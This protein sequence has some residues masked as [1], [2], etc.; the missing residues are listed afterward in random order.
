MSKKYKTCMRTGHTNFWTGVTFG[1]EHRGESKMEWVER[2]G[3]S[4]A[5]L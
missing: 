1:S 5:F 4:V 2:W 3:I